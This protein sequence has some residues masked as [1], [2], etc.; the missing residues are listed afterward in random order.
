[1][2]ILLIDKDEKALSELKQ[3][4]SST[5]EH[6]TVT[7]DSATL[8]L[9]HCKSAQYDIVVINCSMPDITGIAFIYK[10]KELPQYKEVPIL[11]LS[12]FVQKEILYQALELGAND[13]VSIPIDPME[14]TIKLRNL[15][16]LRQKQIMIQNH[17]KQLLKLTE[18]LRQSPHSVV[19]TDKDAV[20]EYVNP[21]F[22]AITG[23]SPEEVIGKKP[24]ILQSGLTP[25]D[26]YHQMWQTLTEGKVW[27]GRLLNKK[28]NGQLYWESISISPVKTPEG[29]IVNYIAIKEDISQLKLLEEKLNE[30]ETLFRTLTQ[31]A[32]VGIYMFKGNF[33]Y[34]NPAM[35]DITGYSTEELLQMPPWSLVE[36][37][38]RDYIMKLMLDIISGHKPKSTFTDIVIQTKQGVKKWVQG[39]A[40][41][42]QY[43]STFVGLGHMI[44]ITERKR[45]EIELKN[46]AT[47]DKLT[48][49][50]NRRTFEDLLVVE[51]QRLKRYNIN[52]SLIMFDIDNFKQINDTYGHSVGDY[53]LVELCKI[54]S[55]NVRSADFLGRWGG[56][57]FML[58]SPETSLED[59]T[60]LAQKLRTIIQFTPLK[61]VSNV[62]VSFGVIQCA[63]NETLDM[64]IKRVDEA[65]YKAKRN[66]RNRVEIG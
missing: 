28:K 18:A 27:S 62:T 37:Q 19:I 11:M 42:V 32:M 60:L 55:S 53:V 16:Y 44:D 41:T 17:E 1:M 23:Y 38:S 52:T 54:V 43:Q 9:R 66:G 35:T 25:A 45:L 12:S 6:T 57:E 56:E 26:T 64:V 40:T 30:S 63:K 39:F 48:G 65:L 8:A 21:K 59:A 51:L 58:L 47:Y 36:P 20:I 3:L 10:L 50:Y 15:V 29:E 2:N 49:V 4:V 13:F 61:T 22:T 5:G 14:F 24:S 33:I 7:F 34:A 46:A 31:N